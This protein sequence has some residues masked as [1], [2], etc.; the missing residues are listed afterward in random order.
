VRCLRENAC[1]TRLEVRLQSG[2]ISRT[3][4]DGDGSVMVSS[5][6]I[7]G[8]GGEINSG[9]EESGKDQKNGKS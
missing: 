6:R 1:I 4:L 8:S 5:V 2:G 9:L 3:G 7:M